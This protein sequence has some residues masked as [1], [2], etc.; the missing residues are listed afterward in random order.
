MSSQAPDFY[1]T[2]PIY[3]IND[4]PH[5]GHAYTTVVCDALARYHRL[6]GREVRFLT[7][8]DEHGQKAA[9]SAESQG[10]S[11]KELADRNVERYRRAW[12]ALGISHDDFIRTT[13]ERHV[14]GAR[15]LWCRITA[16]GDIYKGTY[17]GP[18]CVGCEAYFPESQLVEG[19]CPE[20]P[21]HRVET[22]EEESYF[23]R[24]SKYQDHLLELY[25]QN[26][27]FVTPR[28][29][30]NEVIAFVEGGLDDLSV[31]RTK[32]D[33]GVRVPGDDAHVMYVW[34]EALSNYITA[35]GFGSE[36]EALFHRL[37]PAELQVVGK[38]ILRFHAV[39]WPAFLMSAG[40]EPPQE[41]LAHG[42]WLKNE[43]KMSKTRGN[44]ADPFE[45]VDWFGR[46]GVRW[47]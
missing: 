43:H 14:R 36:D 39:Y 10:I 7:G 32:L 21:E 12:G 46:D 2:T 24:L 19:R 33:W 17:S 18:Y 9:R 6:R 35:L 1:V 4:A 13:E 15:A 22:L 44:V 37:W 41:V 11:P 30:L 34:I 47:F 8:T 3:Y 25:H 42:W 16:N 20:D 28:S 5:M 40:L 38:D 29:R 45:L 26:P 31:S 23:F 27:D